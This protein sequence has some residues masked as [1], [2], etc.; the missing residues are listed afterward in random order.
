MLGA[1]VTLAGVALW[2]AAA[3]V[4]PEASPG[5]Q[6]VGHDRDVVMLAHGSV[7][8]LLGVVA[9]ALVTG[10]RR[11][12][13]ILAAALVGASPWLVLRLAGLFAPGAVAN[14]GVVLDGAGLAVALA[15]AG[16]LVAGLTRDGGAGRPGLSPFVAFGAATT[17]VAVDL[18]A[19]DPPPGPA[20]LVAVGVAATV[21]GT[22]ARWRPTLRASA[23]LAGFTA[24]AELQLLATIAENV[25]V[26][27]RAYLNQT[28]PALA[29]GLGVLG[30]LTLAGV[31]WRLAGQRPRAT[32]LAP[33]AADDATVGPRAR[34]VLSAGAV[35]AIIGAVATTG[36][37][38]LTDL[39]VPEVAWWLSAADLALIVT[40]AFAVLLRPGLVRAGALLGALMWSV[41]AATGWPAVLLVA[42]AIC[43]TGPLVAHLV[44]RVVRRYGWA[45][46]LIAATG[47]GAAAFAA[48]DRA[49]TAYPPAVVAVAFAL[50]PALTAAALP[51][52]IGVAGLA[53]WVAGSAPVLVLVCA[54]HDP[55]AF[56]VA[57]ALLVVLLVAAWLLWLVLTNVDAQPTHR[58]ARPDA[59]PVASPPG[60]GADEGADQAAGERAPAEPVPPALA[61]EAALPGR[62][63]STRRPE[64]AW[65]ELAQPGSPAAPLVPHVSQDLG[66]S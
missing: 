64:L 55:A 25:Q 49:T 42:A 15:G 35:F 31:A 10:P 14:T 39:V 56:P 1:L 13:P 63:E 61:T 37:A 20:A 44:R 50:V 53:G 46:A 4:Y 16:V 36:P 5:R 24:V 33:V 52:R 12:R 45:P 60:P 51:A 40:V 41:V 62:P 7:L 54:R 65:P 58:R 57:L 8:A 9:L 26:H 38:Q 19:L 30:V 28:L 47:A 6:Y 17:L 27:R 43:A 3:L 2:W 29:V 34:L 11:W 22:A 32:G 21:V 23:A 48:G 59:R 18:P 66:P